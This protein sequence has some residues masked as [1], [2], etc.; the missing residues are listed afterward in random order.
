MVPLCR[1][2]PPHTWL[3]PDGD[4]SANVL[5]FGSST[6]LGPAAVLEEVIVSG[7]QSILRHLPGLRVVVITFLEPQ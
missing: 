4:D 1:V 5:L 3:D 2:V 7:I 6:A